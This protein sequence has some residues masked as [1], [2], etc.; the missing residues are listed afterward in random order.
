MRYTVIITDQ[1]GQ[2]REMRGRT[3]RSAARKAL[4]ERRRWPGAC[5]PHTLIFCDREVVGELCE[6]AD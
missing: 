6:Y 4:R 2:K 5:W 3:A 1:W